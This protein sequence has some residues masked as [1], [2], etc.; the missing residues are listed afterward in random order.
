VAKLEEMSFTFIDWHAGLLHKNFLKLVLYSLQIMA[1]PPLGQST[2][3]VVVLL[4]N[5][6]MAGEWFLGIT[7]TTLAADLGLKIIKTVTSFHAVQERWH[8][9]VYGQHK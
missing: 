9:G 5:I 8:K 7:R 4:G 2:I 1:L 3:K 6:C